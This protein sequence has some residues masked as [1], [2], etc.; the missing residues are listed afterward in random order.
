MSTAVARSCRGRPALASTDVM[1]GARVSR[2]ADNRESWRTGPSRARR[3]CA[4]PANGDDNGILLSPPGVPGPWAPHDV[5]TRLA[6]HIGSVG[7]LDAEASLDQEHH[8]GS[9]LRIQPVHAL[10]SGWMDA[11]FQLDV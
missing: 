3:R 8:S 1:D 2:S 7:E 5:V 9:R 4:R 10:V 6:E 11:P